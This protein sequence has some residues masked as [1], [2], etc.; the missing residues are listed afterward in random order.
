MEAQAIA[1][2]RGPWRE[3]VAA[4]LRLALPLILTNL[5]HIAIVTTDIVM[6]GTLGPHALAAA[7][8][9]AA[10]EFTVWMFGVGV[11]TAV[12]PMVA[13]ARGRGRDV[14]RETRRTVQQGLWAAT[15][16]SIPAMAVLAAAGPGLRAMG[17]DPALVADTESYIWGLLWSIAPGLWFVTLRTF[18]A[19]LE[20]PR[21]AAVVTVVAI[22]FNAAAAWSLIHGALGLPALGLFGAGVAAT[23]SSL[24]MGGCMA[25]VVALDGSIARYRVLARLWRPDWQR[26]RE[27]MVIGLPIG[28]MMVAECA[29]FSGATLLMGLIGT[30]AVAA[31][32]IA[33]QCAGVTFMV[34]LGV[35]Q[36][37][38]VR[39]G[40]AI[41]R[42]DR[43]GAARAGWTAFMLGVGFMAAMGL[44][45]LTAPGP[46]VGLFI[47][48]SL[49]EAA[50]TVPLAIGFLFFAAVFQVFD[51]AQVIGAGA[52]RGLKDTGVPMLIAT[53]GYWAVGFP[54]AAGLAFAAGWGGP[55]IWIGLTAGLAVVALLL[56]TRFAARTWVGATL[57]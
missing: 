32:Q 35:G 14:V 43:A 21:P 40:L 1:Y 48:R 26:L 54:L 37:A 5:A 52:L 7:A 25:A 41:G 9:A 30:D 56:V 3:E 45:F 8:L 33:L 42:G 15:L 24:L 36:A 53:V 57:R 34:P 10:L 50:A 11:V 19:A 46:L 18:L 44:V 27:L 20:R 22:F 51:G 13:Q 17:Q 4:T 28:A 47:D 38:T 39:V 23:A 31:H 29:L 16:V 2:E 55:G 49:P 6:I 12:A